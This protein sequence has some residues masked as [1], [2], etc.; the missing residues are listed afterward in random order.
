MFISIPY[1]FRG[2]MC[3]SP[4]ELLYQCDTWFMSLCIDDHLVT[5]DG[6]LHTVT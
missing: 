1:I 6:H 3:P 2:T 5:P 4:G